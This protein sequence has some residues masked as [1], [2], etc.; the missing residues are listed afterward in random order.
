LSVVFAVGGAVR[1]PEPPSL[2]VVRQNLLLAWASYCPF[3]TVE[4]WKC[5]WCSYHDS[6]SLSGVGTAY[7]GS[8]DSF[9]YVGRSGSNIY[10]VFRGTAV[11]SIKNWL[12]DLDFAKVRPW[13]DQSKVQVH[14][15]F[16]SSWVDVRRTTFEL[17]KSAL[18]NC[19]KCSVFFVGHSLGGAVATLAAVEA[20]RHGNLTSNIHL[21]TY[22][23]PRVGNHAFYTYVANLGI[24][25][26]RVVNDDDIVPHVPPQTFDF[27]HVEQEYWWTGS[28]WKLCDMSGEDPS[29]SDSVFPFSWSVPDH[30]DYLNIPLSLGAA[31]KCD[32]IVDNRGPPHMGRRHLKHKAGSKRH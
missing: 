20:L 1:A 17:V 21:Y 16:Y 4:S 9:S 31:A 14:H 12:K 23:S 22:G 26:L 18:D 3:G 2:A 28:K 25:S 7:N 19:P 13:S 10:V 29:C 15:G 24:P 27:R 32:G 5:F 6:L 11:L 30:L 8:S